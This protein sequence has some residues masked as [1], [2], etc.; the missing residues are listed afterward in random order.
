MTP[1]DLGNQLGVAL[2]SVLGTLLVR[3]LGLPSRVHAL[4]P[5]GSSII[6]FWLFVKP[7]TVTAALTQGGVS[8]LLASGMLYI[9]FGLTKS[10]D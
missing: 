1:V 6:I 8:G 5:M 3:R 7:G 10:D 9:L 2:L 4:I